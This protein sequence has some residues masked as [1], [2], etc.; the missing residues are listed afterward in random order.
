MANNKMKTKIE[1]GKGGRGRG[2]E[3]ERGGSSRELP[4]QNVACIVLSGHYSHLGPLPFKLAPGFAGRA[5]ALRQPQQ[6][7]RAHKT[8]A[9]AALTCITQ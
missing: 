9:K 3:G 4:Q 7:P 2:G 1:E 8:T 5:R 6:Q